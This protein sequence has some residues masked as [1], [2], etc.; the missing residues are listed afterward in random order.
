MKYD[1]G[2]RRKVLMEKCTK[3]T[4]MELF[5][6]SFL[7]GC[8]VK[9]YGTHKASYNDVIFYI[10]DNKFMFYKMLKEKYFAV[11]DMPIWT[12]L[13]KKF[14]MKPYETKFIIKEALSKHI[15]LNNYI[16]LRTDEVSHID[17]FIHSIEKKT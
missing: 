13:Q 2:N 10:K 5:V 14:N 8:E 11:R 3:Q 16:V 9:E 1:L 15:D 6:L 4:E 12:P 17:N 7:D